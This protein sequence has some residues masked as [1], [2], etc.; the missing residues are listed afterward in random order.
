M[1]ASIFAICMISPSEKF[2]FV[3]NEQGFAKVPGIQEYENEIFEI[4][5]LECMTFPWPLR[6]GLNYR[7][8]YR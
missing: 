1:L 2:Q 7:G 6:K 8:K 4:K 5:I 3:L